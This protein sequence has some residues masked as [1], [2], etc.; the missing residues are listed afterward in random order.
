MMRAPLIQ[1]HIETEEEWAEYCYYWSHRALWFWEY[2]Y[3]DPLERA[4][5]WM[6]NG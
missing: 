1:H 6:E 3:L 4:Q 2:E 5:R